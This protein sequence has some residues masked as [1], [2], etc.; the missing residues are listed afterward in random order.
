LVSQKRVRQTELLSNEILWKV[1]WWGNHR[2]ADLI[3]SLSFGDTLQQLADIQNWPEPR[4]G[5]EKERA[6]AKSFPSKWLKNYKEL[7]VRS[8]KRY[9]PIIDELRDTVP[10]RVRAYG[11]RK[12]YDGWR[13]LVKQGLKQADGAHG[14]IDARLE[15]LSYCYQSSIYGINVDNASDWQRKILI[16]ILWSSLTRYYFFMTASSWGTWSHKIYLHE[17]MNLPIKLTNNIDLRAEILQIVDELRNW[18]PIKRDLIHL[19]GLTDQ[20]IKERQRSLE[21]R[22]DEAI[23][24]LYD[25]TEAERDLVLDMCDAGLEFFYRESK[26]DAIKKNA[27]YPIGQ[28]IIADLPA[29]R[30]KERGLEGYLYAFLQIWNRQLESIDGEFRWRIIRPPQIPMLAIIFSTQPDGEPLS[31]FSTTDD[32]QAWHKL[33][34]RLDTTLDHPVSS[35]IYIE[36]MVRAVTDTD[37]FIIKRNERR[38]WTRSLA[39]EDAE[40]TLLQAMIIQETRQE[41]G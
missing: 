10:D 11:N 1:Y 7:P 26:S 38:L 36:G 8:I 12:N 2:D 30:N 5:F 40:A 24:K 27:D 9:G 39:R 32:E 4:R 6:T 19:E 3:N 20:A 21:Q 33:L 29:D 17:L 37:I 35:R 18:N 31:S 34:K 15:N 28:G 41:I 16:A 13:L 23:F 22:L 25:L 14:R